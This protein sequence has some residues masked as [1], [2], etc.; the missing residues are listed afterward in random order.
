MK[1]QFSCKHQTIVAWVD[2]L[3]IGTWK[4]YGEGLAWRGPGMERVWR[5]HGE[6]RR[7]PGGEGL[8]ESVWRVYGEGMSVPNALKTL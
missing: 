7:R 3:L 6:G 8:M 1:H 5:G 4:A 2:R